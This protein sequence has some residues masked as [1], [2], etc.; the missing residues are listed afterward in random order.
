[1]IVDNLLNA[2]RYRLL[3]PGIGPAIEFLHRPDLSSLIPGRYDLVG[4][5]VYALVSQYASG[6]MSEHPWEAH[7][8]YIDLHYIVG[9]TERIG[10]APVGR[11]HAESYDEAKDMLRLSGTGDYLTL[12]P[13]HF[14][15]LWPDDAHMPGLADGTPTDVTKVV[16]KIRVDAGPMP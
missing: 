1:V 11:M 3:N 2:R 12:M 4:D 14:M 6:P 16:V 8:R 13:G 10:Y 15:L 7:R 9:G 5:E